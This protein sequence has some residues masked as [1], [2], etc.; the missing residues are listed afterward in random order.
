[1][2][3]HY[4]LYHEAKKFPDMAKRPLWGFPTNQWEIDRAKGQNSYK[5][6]SPT[7]E[8]QPFTRTGTKISILSQSFFGIVWKNF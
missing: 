1:M 7:G 6:W 5:R 3:N 4:H 8:Y 2:N